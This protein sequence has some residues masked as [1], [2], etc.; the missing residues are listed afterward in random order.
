MMNLDHERR[1]IK[2]T[3]APTGDSFVVVEDLCKDDMIT[4]SSRIGRG[5]K[6][7]T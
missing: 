5:F 7:K 4:G 1:L 6:Q 3:M 2:D